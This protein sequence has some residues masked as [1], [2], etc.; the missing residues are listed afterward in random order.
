MGN[1]RARGTYADRKFAAIGR[2]APVAVPPSPVTIIGGHEIRTVKLKGSGSALRKFSQEPGLY[3][4][5]DGR[6]YR[7]DGVSVRRVREES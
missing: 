4:A 5:R 7:W 3:R 6:L 1:A 2:P